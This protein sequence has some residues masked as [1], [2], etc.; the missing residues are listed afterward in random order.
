[1]AVHV[2]SII[3]YPLFGG[4]HNRNIRL[5][6]S[7]G[8]R[9]VRTTMLLPQEP[10]NALQRFR[11]AEVE[12]FQLPLG[13][14]RATRNVT[15]HLWYLARMPYQVKRLREFIRTHGIDVVQLNGLVNPHGAFAAAELGVPVVW[16]I[17]DTYAPVPLRRMFLPLLR[18][19]ADVIMCTGRA[20]ASEHPGVTSLSERIV[21]FYPP[22][23]TDEFTANGEVRSAVRRELGF[24]TSALVIGTLGNICKQKGQHNFVRAA[25]LVKKVIPNARFLVLGGTHGANHDAYLRELWAIAEAAGIKP[26]RDLVLR[27]PARR[28]RDLLQALD[29]FW[30]TPAPRSE[31]IPTAME[32]A[33]ALEIPVA[34]FDVGSISEL[35]GPSEGGILVRG[36]DVARLA[37]CTAEQLTDP[38]QRSRLGAAGRAFVVKHASLSV[39]ARKHM[40]A[41]QR[42]IAA[43]SRRAPA[44]GAGKAGDHRATRSGNG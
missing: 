3:H 5:A 4:P 36:Q 17:V 13:R 33:M 2:L 14:L 1:M 23:D 34:S 6:S 21:F 44:N 8:D 27:D 24:P 38:S 7:L 20:V 19:Y 41:Y 10:G 22:V 35:I 9:G 43:R 18:R 11:D 28:V 31:G 32:E 30:M 42:A 25:A 26:G 12:V 16:Q 37:E 29:V 40:D 15:R 39:T